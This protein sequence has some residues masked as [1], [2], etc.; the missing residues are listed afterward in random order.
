MFNAHD[1][2]IDIDISGTGH[3]AVS[4]GTMSVRPIVSNSAPR[5]PVKKS[6]KLEDYKKRRGII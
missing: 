5:G 1:F 6:L 4:L 2:D 3:S